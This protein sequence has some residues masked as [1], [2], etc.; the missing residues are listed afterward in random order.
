MNIQD[1]AK[2]CGVS[3]STVSKILHNKDDEISAETRKK[4]LEVVKEY[5]Y[6]PYSKVLKNVAHKTHLI[7]VLMNEGAYGA[8]KILYEVE[9]KATE[10]GYGIL[11]CTTSGSKERAVKCLHVFENK[12]VDGV[13]DI[14]QNLD[15]SKKGKIPIIR[16]A[17]T[18]NQI[19]PNGI[20]DI[21]Y[22]MEDVGYMAASQ[23]IEKGHQKIACLLN[24]QDKEVVT[25][26]LRAYQERFYIPRKEWV[27]LEKEEDIVHVGVEKCLNMGVTALICSGVEAGGLIYEKLRARGETIPEALSV[28]S[29]R[30]NR[31]SN[32][33]SPQISTVSIPF[34]RLGEQAVEAMVEVLEEKKS[35]YECRKK[36]FPEYIDRE[37]VTIP[38][39]SG[40]GG[41]IVVV[42]SLHMDS[43]LNLSHIPTEGETLKSKNIAVL[44][45]GKGANQAVGAGKLGGLVYII[46]RIGND[47]NGR[48]I[49]SSL[50]ENGV[51]TEGIVFDETTPTGKAYIN[52]PPNGESTIV[53]Y[54]GANEKL[55]RSQIKQFSYLLDDASY[56]LLTMEIEKET[57]EYTIHK[58]VQK[59]VQVILKPMI[60]EKLDDN[61]LVHVDYI[62]PNEK[63]LSILVPGENSIE[64][65]A[66][67]LL[68]KGVRNVI[69]TLGHKGCYFKNRDLK[70][71][72]PAADFPAI[73]TTGAADAFISA[74]VVFLSEG[75]SVFEAI[76]YA[77]YAA[78][79]SVTR[80]G[81]QSAMVERQELM[82]YSDEI[83]CL[84]QQR[85]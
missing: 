55:D 21:Y 62:V 14:F 58:C 57:V 46:G 1:I 70:A 40:M 7:G 23:L 54:P 77:T 31:L 69:I 30:E 72:F 34:Q 19:R 9:R 56:C 78:G 60:T 49:Y 24:S 27:I 48:T 43:M 3:P 37:S 5:Q 84:S 79:L 20:A 22:E 39:N 8:Q 2:L 36:L 85:Q 11:L 16:I 26:Y 75:K 82:L 35:V 53:T 38:Q 59:H 32:W 64:E 4:V 61:L 81:V 6:V 15:S 66:E 41:K 25:G 52:I 17:N 47:L 28:I 12:G 51:K 45:G 33:M 63:E 65:K 76:G 83:E 44:P 29:I 74:F 18:N 68:G 50:Q 10:N 67:I 13:I 71:W 80:Q 73:D 42:G